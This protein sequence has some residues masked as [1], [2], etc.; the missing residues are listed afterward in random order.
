[1]AH[2]SIELRQGRPPSTAMFVLKEGKAGSRRA[3]GGATH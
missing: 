2:R 3:G 1:M